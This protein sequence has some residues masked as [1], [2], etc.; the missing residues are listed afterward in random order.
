M[1]TVAGCAPKTEPVMATG[2]GGV[3]VASAAP[4][5]APSSAASSAPS[6]APAAAVAPT[7]TSAEG[8]VVSPLSSESR[9]GAALV[10]SEH[11]TVERIFE[12]RVLFLARGERGRLAILADEAGVVIPWRFENGAWD[13]LPLPAL[14]ATQVGQ[15]ALGMYFGRDDR[16]RM[17][18]YRVT[19]EGPRMVYLR[20]RDGAWH[21]QRREVGSLAS[22]T[23]V[24]FGELG[25]A[26]PEVV[27][28]EGSMTI[29]K[30]R[31][32]WN[33]LQSGP[34][35]DA[36]IRAF[37]G[38][39]YALQ[40]DGLF[41]GEKKAFVRMGGVGPWKTPVTGFWV[42]ADGAAA[43]V[44]PAH[45]AIHVLHPTTGVWHTEA[46][47]VPGPRD[48]AG[49]VGNRY[50]VGDGGMAHLGANGARSI[51]E[52]ASPMGRVLLI[53]DHVVASGPGG[54]YRIQ[55]R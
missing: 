34:P 44:E 43:V 23:A 35:K 40:S 20:Y 5:S 8:S 46:S 15:G 7:L 11:H 13:K 1:L 21:D 25:E 26:D 49:P 36:V 9:A 32:G 42:G 55:V 10:G 19:A 37:S 41:R 51:G 3:L 29:I 31:F 54:V 28:R 22:D 45:D 14:H 33:V 24:L 52:P 30:G 16:P 6:S 17:M 53:D 50:I 39:G 48:V 47:P 38:Y 12:A 27:C 2:F 18:G 4:R